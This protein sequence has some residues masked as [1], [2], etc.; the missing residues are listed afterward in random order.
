MVEWFR[1]DLNAHD[2]LKIRKL[3][4]NY[5]ECAYGAYW[6]IVELLYQQG[7]SA[8]AEVIS[9][10][11]ELM[12]SPNM[13]EILAESGLFQ[14]SEDGTW[15]SKRITEEFAYQEER[16]KKIVEAGR[17]GGLAKASNAKAMLN[18][19]IANSSGAIAKSSNALANS[20]TIQDNT[21]QDNNITL[22]VSKETSSPSGKS[23]SLKQSIFIKPS[24][25]EVKA[26]CQER[27]NNV[28]A[29]EFIDYYESVGW[30]VG[31][32]KKM[33]D[34]KASVRT[35]E[36]D[37]TPS[38]SDRNDFYGGKNI[39]GTDI[40]MDLVSKGADRNRY[41]GPALEDLL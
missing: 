9:D 41:N 23:G 5:G 40:Q 31:K 29:E 4:R 1:H 34:W 11:F 38:K 18:N 6:L 7:G 32:G 33:K 3:L 39:K 8:S 26:Y 37:K 36:K 13:K 21:K 25:E 24:L 30:I 14:I 15:T 28:N 17:M 10:T 35:W 19:A 22:S 27:H 2:D 16:R 20:S 12:S